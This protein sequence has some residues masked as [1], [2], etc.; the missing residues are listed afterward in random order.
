MSK[1]HPPT[2]LTP[3]ECANV[4]EITLTAEPPLAGY[5]RDFGAVRLTSVADFALVSV[6]L[7]LGNEAKAQKAIKTAYGAELP[8]PGHYAEGKSGEQLIRT[9][10]DQGLIAFSHPSPD[11]E[12]VVSNKISHAAYTTDQSDVWVALDVSGPGAIP[13]LERICPLDLHTD[14]FTTDMAQ[15]TVMEHLGVLIL[16]TG[17]ESFRLMSASS[18]ASSFLHA[19]EVSA[20]NTSP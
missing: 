8:A 19:V 4:P 18:S 20:K 5:D 17:P 2:T 7:P 15:R 10:P 9:G 13:A 12:T 16:R 3:K 6:A 11:A 1:S 14:H